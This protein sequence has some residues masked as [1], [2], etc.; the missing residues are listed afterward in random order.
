VKSLEESAAAASAE[1]GLRNGAAVLAAVSGGPDS[2]ALLRVL[3]VLREDMTLSLSACVVD[4][5]IRPA[6]EIDADV[7]FVQGLCDTLRVPLSVARVPAGMLR[8]RSARTGASLEEAARETRH[9]LLLKAARDS[10][11]AMIALGHT[12]DD[13]V[14]TLLMRVL[15]GAGVDGLR[16]IP[17]RR[18]PFF[19]PLIHCTRAQ[20]LDYLSSL[21]QGWRE[22][23]T[24]ADTAMLRNRVRHLLL[25]VLR[26]S[27]PGY[28]AGLLTM[29]RRLLPVSE[30]VRAE[31]ALL[32]WEKNG[33]GF[34]I[35]RAAFYAAP[36]AARACSLLDRYDSFRGAAS[37]RRL[38]W[39]FLAPALRDDPRRDG[40]VLQAHGAGLRLAGNFVFWGPRL[41]SRGKKGYFMEVFEAGNTAIEGT[42]VFLR[43]ARNRGKASEEKGVVSLLAKAVE[44]PLV[45]RS[46]RKGDEILL[47]GGVTPLKELFAGW[48]VSGPDRERMPLLAD[49]K[50]VL[51]VLG[52]ALGYHDRAR[53][54]ALGG[55]LEIADRIEVRISQAQGRGT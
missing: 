1:A 55:D 34:A 14:E 54:G 43:L 21:S 51:A 11:A 42:G 26:E 40:W 2:T 35:A 6:A 10:G 32:P 36:P 28:R 4:H 25:P 45:L 49:K 44:A 31:A 48:K 52:S 5:G 17:L 39:R 53:A 15:Q 41:A 8:E 12:E 23:A 20:V 47:E 22:D 46:R 37:P 16:G 13:V 50:G 19:R 30:M 33:D 38:P 9:R 3:A 27:F 7:S 18:G 29:R 24:N